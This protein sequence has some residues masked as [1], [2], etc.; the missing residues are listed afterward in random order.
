MLSNYLK[1]AIRN[2][3]KNKLFT[4]L[5]LMGLALGIAVALLLM[6]FVKD[7][8]SFDRYHTKIDRIYRG[9]VEVNF[10]DIKENWSTYPNIVGPTMKDE[11]AG[12]EEQMRM[13][14]HNFG[15][16]AFVHA[17]DKNFVQKNFCWADS[18][19]LK[20]FDVKLLDGDAKTALNGPN[21]VILSKSVAEKY[22]QD[23]DPIGLTI[24]IDNALTLDVTGVYADFPQNS[25]LDAEIIGS[26]PSMAWT[27]RDMSWSNASFETFFLLRP[28]ADP[29]TIEQQFAKVYTKYVPKEDQWLKFGLQPMKEVHLQ[30]ANI[31][32]SYSDRIGDPQQVRILIILA[33]I[34]LIIACI[35]Y[36]NLATARSQQRYREVGITKTVGATRAQLAR[37]F[38]LETAVLVL[39]ALALG[40]GLLLAFL[41]LFNQLAGKQ[42]G[43]LDVLSPS[44][45]M[46]LGLIGLIVTLV[47]GSYP[48]L[49]LSSFNPKNLLQTAFRQKSS[50]GILRRS[51]VVV[52]F[53]ASIILM[54]CTALFFQQLNFIQQQNLGYKPEQVVAINMAAAETRDQINAFS[55]ACKALGSVQEVT[56]AQTFPGE[57][58]SGRSVSRSQNLKQTL[59]VQTNHANAEILDVLDIKLLAGKTIPIAEKTQDDTTVQVVVNKIITDFLGYTPEEAIGKKA[60]NMFGYSRAEIV[61]VMDNFHF[62]NFHQ[63]I[64]GYAFHNSLTEPRTYSLIKLNTSNLPA[65]MRQIEE[66][67]N[68]VLPTSAFDYTFLDDHLNTLY[69]REQRTASVVLVFS[70]LAILI[71]CLGLF[72]L[73]AFTAEQ[74]TK[75]IGVRKVLGATIGSIVSLLSRDFLRL[76]MISV[77]IATPVAWYFMNGWLKEF[78]YRID[79]QWWVFV[80][81]G[82]V[83][84]LIAFLTVSMQSVRA[85]A[86]NPVKSLRSE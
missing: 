12:I 83:A 55:N 20:I 73:A 6:V 84:L 39:I 49:M 51:L 52:Q 76:V 47:A 16:P 70:C 5:N 66:T 34:I 82:A 27:V 42:F 80:V 75:E 3:M 86:A 4:G 79:I 18:S 78:A 53:S 67:F 1:I 48:A 81:A 43:I 62:D 60:I 9:V 2:L 35:N 77:V 41:P 50:A 57:S 21:K 45:L 37:R 29:K 65:S 71:A 68:R 8:L 24:K 56:R 32:H 30:S 69:R 40:I 46:G 72:G 17:G 33:I 64:G 58:A 14:E 15:E 36:M 54:I 10:G 44:V 13:W 61:G 74:R 23:E 63:P 28:G 25:T 19:I 85:A 26:F 11:V 31:G 38:Y 59:P 7:E 22:F